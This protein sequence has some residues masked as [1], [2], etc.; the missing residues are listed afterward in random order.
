MM[1]T[2]LASYYVGALGVALCVCATAALLVC[3]SKRDRGEKDKSHH[4]SKITKR[5]AVNED[6]KKRAAF[7]EAG[8]IHESDDS[9]DDADDAELRQSTHR[10]RRLPAP[11]PSIAESDLPLGASSSNP[12]EIVVA[13]DS[14]SPMDASAVTYNGPMSESSSARIY[15]T[16]DEVAAYN[17]S[18]SSDYAHLYERIHPSTKPAAEP[19]YHEPRPLEERNS[20]HKYEVVRSLDETTHA[21][22]DGYSEIPNERARSLDEAN[23]ADSYYAQIPDNLYDEVGGA[24]AEPKAADAGDALPPP[25]CEPFADHV[26]TKVEKRRKRPQ[27]LQSPRARRALL[28]RM[29]AKI[30]KEKKR[31]YRKRRSLDDVSMR[32]SV[33]VAITSMHRQLAGLDFIDDPAAA[34]SAAATADVDEVARQSSDL[35]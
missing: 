19:V 21:N 32:Q 10:I 33:D 6:A 16:I 26:Y 3:I 7:V 17:S 14:S 2:Q 22:A 24:R 27:T 35:V 34:T 11:P 18:L 4:Y 15:S 13:N 25:P 9:V 28:D 5:K 29:Y 23:D 20:H 31:R 8:L 30:D 1:T 12:A